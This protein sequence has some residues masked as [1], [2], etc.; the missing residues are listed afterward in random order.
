MEFEV[1][2]EVARA[3]QDERDG[4]C[5]KEKLKLQ[6]QMSQNRNVDFSINSHIL[7]YRFLPFAFSFIKTDTEHS[8]VATS[9][10]CWLDV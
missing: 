5:V 7:L 2:R 10:L 9:L 4:E 3:A 6:V 8:Y 1:S